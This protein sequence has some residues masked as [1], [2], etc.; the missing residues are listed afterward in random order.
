M[1]LGLT[2]LKAAAERANNAEHYDPAELS[3]YADEVLSLIARVERLEGVLRSVLPPKR[4]IHGGPLVGLK[5][6]YEDGTDEN[7]ARHK[8]WI[9]H[10]TVEAA[11]AAL[12]DGKMKS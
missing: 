3:A 10:A 9:D 8:G 12:K 7:S 2:K 1:T 11:R 5:A 4:G 6:R